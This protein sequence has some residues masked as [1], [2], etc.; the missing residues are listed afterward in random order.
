MVLTVA[1]AYRASAG[2]WHQS[3]GRESA[4]A[5]CEEGWYPSWAYWPND[6][7]GG[8]VCNREV[9]DPSVPVAAQSASGGGSTPTPSLPTAWT[10]IAGGTMF[11]ANGAT[12]D[13]GDFGVAPPCDAGTLEIRVTSPLTVSLIGAV[14]QTVILS[15]QSGSDF[16]GAFSVD[17]R[18]V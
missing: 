7:T 2:V 6:G 5:V 1:V 18:C 12:S 16:T 13:P 10:S 9:D 14:P 15:N 17:T 11:L 4:D 8:W 3:Y